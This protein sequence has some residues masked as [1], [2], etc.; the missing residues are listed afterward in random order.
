MLPGFRTDEQLEVFDTT[1]LQLTTINIDLIHFFSIRLVEK[2]IV[3][4]LVT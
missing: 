3:N 1:P 2:T 4:I